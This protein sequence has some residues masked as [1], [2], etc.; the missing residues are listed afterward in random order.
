MGFFRLV[1]RLQCQEAFA[2]GSVNL[3][4]SS[5]TFAAAWLDHSIWKNS[6]A[7]SQGWSLHF[8]G[9]SSLFCLAG[10][11]HLLNGQWLLCGAW[12]SQP[13]L[14]MFAAPIRDLVFIGDVGVSLRQEA[15]FRLLPLGTNSWCSVW[16][17]PLVCRSEIQPAVLTDS[18]VL[19]WYEGAQKSL[20]NPKTSTSNT[21]FPK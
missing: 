19:D 6:C 9:C 4:K 14:W 12:L 1:Y 17:F 5:L 20:G 10:Q 2:T 3:G 21:S 13:S 18:D 8:S 11:S 7:G 16:H 15:V